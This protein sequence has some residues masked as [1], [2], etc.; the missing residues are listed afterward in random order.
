[1]CIRD[2]YHRSFNKID[3]FFSYIGGLIGTILGFMLFMNNFSLM[4]FELDIAQ[5]FFQYKKDENNDFSSFNIFSYFGYLVFKAGSFCGLCKNWSETKKKVTC[6]EEMLKQLDVQL[7][8]Q[9]FSF[10]ER[11]TEYLLKGRQI[12]EEEFYQL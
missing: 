5:R 2:S 11:A 6:K 12:P 7:F 4:S 8:L 3:E 9:R 10:L 1:M